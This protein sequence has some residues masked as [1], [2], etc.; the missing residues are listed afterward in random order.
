MLKI[1]NETPSERI[2][3]NHQKKTPKNKQTK[4]R[5]GK[6]ERKYKKIR[7]SVQEISYPKRGFPE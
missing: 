3:K 6:E 1:N 5:G 7:E 4:K 2:K